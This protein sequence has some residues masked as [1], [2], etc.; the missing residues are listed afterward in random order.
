MIYTHQARIF[1]IR[2]PSPSASIASRCATQV[3]LPV[4]LTVSAL[5][6]F[7]RFKALPDDCAEA[8]CE[9]LG[10]R[11]SVIPEVEEV[12]RHLTSDTK[13]FR[14]DVSQIAIEGC[15]DLACKVMHGRFFRGGPV[16]S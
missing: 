6:C 8:V 10:L 4:E 11:H 7:S 15:I 12:L 1:R 2:L 14:G 9:V 16:G 13:E 3:L 5:H